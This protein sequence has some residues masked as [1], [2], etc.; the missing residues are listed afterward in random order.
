MAYIYDI[1]NHMIKLL[2]RI[3]IILCGFMVIQE[4]FST[5]FGHFQYKFF[6]K[7]WRVKSQV[8]VYSNN[9][10]AVHLENHPYVFVQRG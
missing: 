7:I 9:C 6:N 10:V 2:V 8:I 3:E 1:F 5:L 4:R